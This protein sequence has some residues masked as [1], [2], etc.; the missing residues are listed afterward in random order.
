M[1]RRILAT[2]ALAGAVG[3]AVAQ[4][5]PPGNN[6]YLTQVSLQANQLFYSVEQL[7]D[8]V[9]G[10][11]RGGQLQN[12]VRSTNE[13]YE[14]TLRFVRMLKSNPPR[15]RVVREYQRLDR[16]GDACVADCRR[17]GGTLQSAK[18][19]QLASR[20]EY[21]DRQLAGA[22]YAGGG[23]AGPPAPRVV[24]LCRA[25]DGQA[26]TLLRLAIAT[27]NFSPI[28]AQF[29]RQL[30]QFTRASDQLRRSAEAN[31]DLNRLAAEYGAVLP[32]WEAVLAYFAPGSPLG[33]S[34][35]VRTQATYVNN[36]MAQLGKV[37]GRN[38][39]PP[40]APIP[41][42]GPGPGPG[43]VV[44]PGPVWPGINQRQ[45]ALFAIGA[46]AGGGPHVR[47][48]QSGR[49]DDY[50]D[51]LA[52]DPDF[53]GGVRV[54]LGDVDGDGIRD[55]ICAPG[56]GSV[57]VIRVFSGRDYSLITEFFAFDQAVNNGVYVAA[58][59]ITRNGRAEIICGVGEGGA[60]VVRV[61]EGATGR[62]LT[63]FGAYEKGFRGGVRVAVGDVNGDGIKDIVTAPGPGRPALIR[64][65][66]GRN[67]ANVLA[68]FDAYEVAFQGGAFVAA[69]DL[70]GDGRADII[71]GAGTGGGP[72][73]R[74][75]DIARGMQ[76]EYFA[77]DRNFRGG[78]RIACRD[79]NG[80][81]VPDIVCAPG[82]GLP[83]LIKVLDG[84]TRTVTAE[85]MAYDP[86]FVGGAFIGCRWAMMLASVE[87]LLNVVNSSTPG[88]RLDARLLQPNSQ[89]LRQ[90]PLGISTWPI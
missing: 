82:P 67:A 63:E 68:Q 15:D 9:N 70:T 88:R 11:L 54:A 69:A 17:L 33:E 81:G 57:P 25:L 37:V 3:A 77:Y 28:Q 38:W 32:T 34:S 48:F 10:E 41:P 83:S 20:I 40:V 18:L 65:F 5:V 36:L 59:D 47:V 75:W 46:D 6:P 55:V 74:V 29:D 24:R 1:F 12:L 4:F 27:P 66:D 43:P 44:P 62:M 49:V 73:V 84:R 22:V 31:A 56:P 16:V 8:L 78:V 71:T 13:Y 7:R 72:N 30:K 64:V 61:F 58:A 80:D 35:A 87:A 50:F 90:P 23:E 14:D 2:V 45:K 85:F 89:V 52:Y 26:E 53:R 60:P 39:Q 42:P 19:L 76:F 51:F 86:R 79:L 21:A